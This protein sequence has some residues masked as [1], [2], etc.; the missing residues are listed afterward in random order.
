M[1]GQ[2]AREEHEDGAEPD[3]GQVE[4]TTDLVHS[5][6]SEA[7]AEQAKAEAE[8]AKAEA[9]QARAEAEQAKAEAERRAA[10]EELLRKEAEQRAREG[11]KKRK[12]DEKKKKEDEKKKKEAGER[13][14]EA[15][16][17]S[18]KDATKAGIPRQVALYA[19]WEGSSARARA[20]A[21][22]FVW[23]AI[24]LVF[25]LAAVALT[26]C[27]VTEQLILPVGGGCG[28]GLLLLAVAA[29]TKG[30][31]AYAGT[32]AEFLDEREQVTALTEHS[33][34][35]Q[36]GRDK[37]LDE[38]LRLNRTQMQA[39]QTLSRGQQRSAFRSSLIALFIGL[40]VLVGGVVVVVVV[41]GSTSKLA[42]AGVTALGSALSS[43]I[44]STY[45][46]LHREAARQLR[47]FSDQPIVTSYIYEAERLVGK[48]PTDERPETYRV[49][50]NDVLGLAHHP[51]MTYSQV[52]E[53]ARDVALGDGRGR[54]WGRKPKRKGSAQVAGD[55]QS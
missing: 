13:Q 53:V 44:A 52:E 34:G 50:I 30:T 28:G 51:A 26:V 19:Q 47:F 29:F 36:T 15:I 6:E 23:S 45:L 16:R 43:Y 4:P 2:G 32:L 5:E 54:V 20:R 21:T 18:V 11:E 22:L 17:Q 35:Q 27:V 8:Q 12:E 24:A 41:E 40:G 25:V 33:L 46:N 14:N 10:A 1:V 31:Y 9:E 48:L 3:A 55:P 38:L 42:V 37:D 49:V 7:E 39:Y